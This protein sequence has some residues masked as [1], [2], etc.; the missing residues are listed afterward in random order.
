MDG[1]AEWKEGG[2]EAQTT[3]KVYFPQTS[4]GDN[5]HRVLFREGGGSVISRI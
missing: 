4:S 5:K 3:R 1:R 2:T